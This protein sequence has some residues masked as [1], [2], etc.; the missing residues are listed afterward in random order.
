MTTRLPIDEAARARL[1]EAQKAEVTALK[2]VQTAGTARARARTA[3]DSAER[4]LAAAKVALV[5][6]SGASRAA[7]LLNEPVKELQRVAR[8]SGVKPPSLT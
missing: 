2:R 7:L 1:R 5:R 6:T 4:A 8:E 3:L